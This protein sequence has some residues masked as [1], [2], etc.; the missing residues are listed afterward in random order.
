ML[1]KTFY[2][3]LLFFVFFGILYFFLFGSVYEKSLKARMYFSLGDYN[4]AY[5]LAREVYLKDSYNTMALTVMNKSKIALTYKKYIK[6]GNTYLNQIKEI[7]SKKTISKQELAKI[8]MIC[9]I[10]IGEYEK[11]K[12]NIFT[13]KNLSSNTTKIYEKFKKIHEEL[14]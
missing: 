1:K 8:K 5:S 10:M 12:P 11:L 7:G 4:K 3:V 6:E 9:E 14:F 2:F 13:D